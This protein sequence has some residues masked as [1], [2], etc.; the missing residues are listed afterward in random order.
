MAAVAAVTS[1]MK[2]PQCYIHTQVVH[3]Y[4]YGAAGLLDMQLLPALA[5]QLAASAAAFD[6][7][8]LDAAA[9]QSP[10]SVAHAAGH[11]QQ[12]QQD[13]QQEHSSSQPSVQPVRVIELC[14]G[15]I[16]N[17]YSTPAVVQQLVSQ[18]ELTAAV[19]ALLTELEDAPALS[20]LARL[21]TAAV[22]TPQVGA[23]CTGARAGSIQKFVCVSMRILCI[24]AATVHHSS[25]TLWDFAAAA[26]AVAGNSAEQHVRP[27]AA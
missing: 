4:C 25:L 7:A 12:D 2:T 16:A 21:L 27:S 8:R 17:L 9:A 5:A 10:S 24:T 26:A 18:T 14:C 6:R 23:G 19:A 3:C 1:P 13:Q 22:S 11:Q 15:I 20:E